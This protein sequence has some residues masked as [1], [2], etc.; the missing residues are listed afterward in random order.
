M[1][2]REIGTRALLTF[3]Q[4]FLAVLLVDG[5][6]GIDSWEAVQPAVI[7]AVAALLSMLYRVVREYQA[8]KGWSE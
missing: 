2:W 8:S 5:L 4:A 3:V 1:N 6:N 7:A